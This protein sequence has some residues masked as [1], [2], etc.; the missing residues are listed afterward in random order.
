MTNSSV[1]SNQMGWICVDRLPFGDSLAQG[2]R[3][4]TAAMYLVDHLGG[5]H[6]GRSRLER[7]GA[8][9][10]VFERCAYI[11]RIVGDVGVGNDS[12]DEPDRIRLSPYAPGSAKALTQLLDNVRRRLGCIAI[13]A[14]AFVEHES[15]LVAAVSVQAGRIL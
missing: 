11:L 13:L 4:G 5:A 1:R 2:V 8:G 6:A 14:G 15:E 9:Y 7:F 12:H 3:N 10:G